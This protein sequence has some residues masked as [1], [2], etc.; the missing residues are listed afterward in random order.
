MKDCFDGQLLVAWLR[1]TMDKRQ[2]VITQKYN[3]MTM[4]ESSAGKGGLL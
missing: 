4:R 3:T 1:N 2:R